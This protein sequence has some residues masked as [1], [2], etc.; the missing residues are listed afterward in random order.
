MI[1]FLQVLLVDVLN[2]S[3][4]VRPLYVLFSIHVAVGS[5]RMDLHH[6]KVLN[7]G[8]RG[9]HLLMKFLFK[10]FNL[11]IVSPKCKTG[12][13]LI[14]GCL[15]LCYLHTIAQLLYLTP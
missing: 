7:F 12:K 11:S 15:F 8:A 1:L 13:A 3:R 10:V 5:G 14:F 4:E 6:F 2:L 9:A